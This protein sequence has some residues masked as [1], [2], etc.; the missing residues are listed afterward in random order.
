MIKGHHT[1]RHSGYIVN[2]WKNHTA[3]GSEDDW[4]QAHV[5]THSDS[6]KSEYYVK[7]K[8]ELEKIMAILDYVFE[9]GKKQRSKEI[10]ELI[11]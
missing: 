10:A 4:S 5:I 9:A 6:Y 7:S 8:Y 1:T 2:Y 11:K 3:C